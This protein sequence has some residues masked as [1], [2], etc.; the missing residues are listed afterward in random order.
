MKKP[1]NNNT[2]KPMASRLKYLSIKSRIGSPYLFIRNATNINRALLLMA[3]ATKKSG[4]L[5]SNAPA[6]MV[7]NLKG[8]GV[9]PAVKI[10]IKLY[11]SYR[12]LI[13]S[14]EFKLNPGTCSKKNCAITENSPP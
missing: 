12:C 5:I 2:V 11:C 1:P 13:F 9:N 3:P 10:I 6:L 7:N 14:N 4:K 8:I